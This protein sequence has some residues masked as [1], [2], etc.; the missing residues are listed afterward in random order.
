MALLQDPSIAYGN[1]GNVLAIGT[2]L[3]ASSNTNANIANF[4]TNTL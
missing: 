3:N 1:A 2:T 4:S